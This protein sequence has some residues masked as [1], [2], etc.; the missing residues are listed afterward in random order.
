ML[1]ILLMEAL[2]SITTSGGNFRKIDAEKGFM[3][4]TLLDSLYNVC[5]I[6]TQRFTW[7]INCGDRNRIKSF[8]NARLKISFYF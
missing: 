3:E 8:R 5:T 7:G 1:L 2:S 6:N 4:N